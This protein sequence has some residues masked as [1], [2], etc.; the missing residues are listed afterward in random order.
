MVACGARLTGTAPV[1]IGLP[2]DGWDLAVVDADGRRVGPGETGELIIGGC[3]PGPLPRP[4]QGR[5]EVRADAVPRLGPGLSQ[6]ATWWCTTRTGLLFVGRADDQVKL[7]GR[8]IELGEIDNALLDLPGV[9]GAAAAVRGH[10]VRQPVAGRLCRRRRQLR[11]DRRRGELLRTRLPA[12]LV[13]RLAVVDDLP[14]R[15]SG[16]IDRDALPWPLPDVAA[17]PAAHWSSAGPPAWIAAAVAARSSEPAVDRD[18]RGLLRPRRRQPDRSSAGLPTADQSS[19]RSPSPTSTSTRR[20]AGL[21]ADLDEMATPT[22]PH[23]RQRPAR[24]RRRP[25]SGR[26]LSPFP[27]RTIAGLR[28][29]IWMR[30]RQQR[31]PQPCSG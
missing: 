11:R 21:A 25:S 13:P 5:R 20:S 2:L 18:D 10:C 9:N 15:T 30:P 19:P 27:L 23:N 8:R 14:T 4:E 17:T 16:K 3:R 26:S 22:S 28:W 7:G 24:C 6:R 31:R 12:A 29:L 1:R